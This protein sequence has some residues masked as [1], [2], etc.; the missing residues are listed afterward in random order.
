M[1]VDMVRHDLGRVAETGSITVPR[2]F[3]VEK[4][5]TVWQMT[6]TVEART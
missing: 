6:S 3:A 4:Y 1:I 5:P 2:L